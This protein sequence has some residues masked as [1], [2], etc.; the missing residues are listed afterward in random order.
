MLKEEEEE[1]KDEPFNPI[2]QN[3]DFDFTEE[4]YRLFS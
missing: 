4:A 1:K 2:P 3:E